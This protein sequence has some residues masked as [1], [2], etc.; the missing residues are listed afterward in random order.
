L[1]GAIKSEEQATTT[2]VVAVPREIDGKRFY[3]Q[4]EAGRKLGVSSK[5][6]SNWINRKIV[7][8]PAMI[9]Q[10]IRQFYEF[11]DRWVAKAREEIDAYRRSRRTR[12]AQR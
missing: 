10:G 2:L 9:N 5:T 7:S 6:L 4:D 8:E 12:R 3:T 1:E 11:T